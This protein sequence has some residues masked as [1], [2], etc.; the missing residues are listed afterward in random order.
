MRGG[1]VTVHGK[2]SKTAFQAG[3]ILPEGEL[4]DPPAGWTP[5]VQAIWYELASEV[6]PGVAGRSD[7]L[8]F[9]VLVRLVAMVRE[10]PVTL[11]PAMAAQIRAACSEFG[12][13]PSARARIPAPPKPSKFDGLTGPRN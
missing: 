6:V 8:A 10:D 1:R 12:M 3:E 9:E 5:T 13:T 4:G 7:R 11:T 2:A